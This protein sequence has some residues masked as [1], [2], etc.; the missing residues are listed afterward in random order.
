MLELYKKFRKSRYWIVDI[1]WKISMFAYLFSS[2]NSYNLFSKI[3][4][5]IIKTRFNKYYTFI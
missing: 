1:L 5:L 3:S 2:T 4:T